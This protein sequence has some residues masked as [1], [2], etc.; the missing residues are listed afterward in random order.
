MGYRVQVKRSALKILKRA[1]RALRT[2]LW[3][4]ISALA[5]DPRPVGCVKLAGGA[6]LWRVRVGDYRV[7]YQVRDHERE[8]LVVVVAHRRAVYR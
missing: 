8:V 6:N 2:R 4:A 1:P 7:I 5:D 3:V